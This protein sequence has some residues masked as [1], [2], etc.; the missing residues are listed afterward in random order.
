MKKFFEYLSSIAGDFPH[1]TVGRQSFQ[2]DR[3]PTVRSQRNDRYVK[4]DH[5]Y[6]SAF[7]FVLEEEKTPM[8]GIKKGNMETTP[9]SPITASKLARYSKVFS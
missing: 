7:A 3:H 4:T 6:S 5:L 9:A 2:N 8:I 1:G